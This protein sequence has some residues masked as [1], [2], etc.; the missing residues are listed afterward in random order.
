MPSECSIR[1]RQSLPISPS[2]ARKFYAEF[3][4]FKKLKET[5]MADCKVPLT[6]ATKKIKKQVETQTDK[7][8]RMLAKFALNMRTQDALAIYNIPQIV[9]RINVFST[10]ED[11]PLLITSQDTDVLEAAKI[12]C[13]RDS[14]YLVG[15]CPPVSYSQSYGASSTR[16]LYLPA[17]NIDELREPA[18]VCALAIPIIGPLTQR[19]STT[20]ATA[21]ETAIRAVLPK[22]GQDG[23]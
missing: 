15:S 7:I 17:K 20:L 13:S 8:Y 11:L 14:A 2:Q 10:N 6:N 5:S 9:R 18:E 21:I 12:I 16:I 3:K 23:C 4:K 22:L 1:I 19:R